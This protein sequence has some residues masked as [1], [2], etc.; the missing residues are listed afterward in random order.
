LPVSR[1]FGAA[2]RRKSASGYNFI[3]MSKCRVR[4]RGNKTPA[5]RAAGA[6]ATENLEVPINSRR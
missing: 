2:E 5:A 6:F 4:R 1:S 3:E